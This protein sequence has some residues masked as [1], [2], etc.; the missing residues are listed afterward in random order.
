MEL[1]ARIW[2]VTA[3]ILGAMAGHPAGAEPAKVF[4]M[5]V[6]TVP[7]L[8]QNNYVM[9]ARGTV[10][11]TPNFETDVPEGQLI[12]TW[13]A[14]IDARHPAG[15]GE[16]ADDACY[17]ARARRSQVDGQRGDIRRLSVAWPPRA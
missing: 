10:Y 2:A 13:K 11:V 4:C 3:A 7:M 5:A 6:R 12:A 15:V 9:G 14:F 17:P 8:D 16:D 1:R